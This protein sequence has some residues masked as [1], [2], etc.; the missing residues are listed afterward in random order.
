MALY[1]VNTAVLTTDPNRQRQHRDRA[2]AGIPAQRPQGVVN[3]LQE[4]LDQWQA[5][6]VAMRF[7]QLR[8]AA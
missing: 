7:P 3:I 2:E 8:A 5:A 6:C 4:R 1:A